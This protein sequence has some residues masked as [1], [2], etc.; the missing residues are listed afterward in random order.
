MAAKHG[1]P[2]PRYKALDGISYFHVGTSSVWLDGGA[3]PQERF[4]RANVAR[5]RRMVAT[6][7]RGTV[8]SSQKVRLPITRSRSVWI[9]GPEP[10]YIA[11]RPTS[12]TPTS[13][14]TSASVEVSTPDAAA[15]S[16]CPQKPVAIAQ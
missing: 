4:D 5:Q 1:L 13:A 3:P 2:G 7:L 12:Q 11:S 16:T 10:R 8:E 9:N 15:G 14:T 6:T